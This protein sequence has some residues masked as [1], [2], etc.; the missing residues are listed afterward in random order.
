MIAGLFLL[1]CATITLLFLL[2]HSET[3]C[4]CVSA[5]LTLFIIGTLILLG[6]LPE[7]IFATEGGG[8][9]GR[10]HR[11]SLGLMLTVAGTALLYP[12]VNHVIY[13]LRD[14]IMEAFDR[15]YGGRR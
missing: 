15:R 11:C 2:E 13:P 9:I 3:A 6:I 12:L 7:N 10:R 8:F 1:L 4:A 5:M 14:R